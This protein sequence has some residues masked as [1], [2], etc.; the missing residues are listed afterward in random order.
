[1]CDVLYGNFGVLLLIVNLV[2]DD[3]KCVF[4]VMFELVIIVM[5]IG[6]VIGVLFGVVVVVKY[7]CLIDYIVCFVGLIGNLVLVFWF[8]LMG[9]LLFYVWLYWVGG[10]GWFDFVYDG[11]VDL[12]IGSLLFDVVFVGE[13]DVFCN[14]VL[15]IVLLVVIFGYYLVVYFSCMMC[16]FMF[17]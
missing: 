13:W 4:L 6:I 5:L 7:N 15:Y 3:I 8:G 9:L 14:V 12:C 2:F 17:D 10:F 11:M 16:L 1:M